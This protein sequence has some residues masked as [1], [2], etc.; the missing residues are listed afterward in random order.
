MHFNLTESKYCYS[1]GSRPLTAL[2]GIVS[3]DG[4]LVMQDLPQAH[5]I[6]ADKIYLMLNQLIG[7]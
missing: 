6:C 5:R 3:R 4:E 7:K 1:I 2:D